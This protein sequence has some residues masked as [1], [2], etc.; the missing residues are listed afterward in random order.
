PGTGVRWAAGR[1]R[2]RLRLPAGM[3]LA[4]DQRPRR[5]GGGR[6]GRLPEHSHAGARAARAPARGMTRRK[7]YNAPTPNPPPSARTRTMDPLILVDGSS[8]LFRA[9]HAMPSLTNS[10]G[11]PTGAIYGVVNMLK[12]LLTDYRPTRLAVVFDAK[13]E[14]FRSELLRD[15]E[16]NRPSMPEDLAGQ[17]G[18]MH[19]AVRAMGL[20]LLSAEGVEAADVIGTLA[21]Q[22][23]DEG[24]DV[25]I[26][27]GD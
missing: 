21:R 5:R 25:V 3:A 19:A 7:G 1:V 26:V 15:Y 20:P 12:K 10:H 23:A 6:R 11:E 17:I 24:T 9:F 22:A 27:S 4:A 16:A 8:Y 13:G 14:T 18:D 2:V